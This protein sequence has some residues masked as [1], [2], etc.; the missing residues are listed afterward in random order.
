M[1]AGLISA[2][3]SRPGDSFR[4]TVFQAVVVNGAQVIPDNT[5]V[6]LQMVAADDGLTVQ[7][8]GITIDGL[9]IAAGPSQVALDPQTAASN[10]VIQ[11]AIAAMAA[12]PRGAPPQLAARL[13][14]VSGP[15]LNLPSGSRIVFTLLAPVAIDGTAPV[16]APRR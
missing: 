1:T 6:D 12:R 15:R 16:A 7:L 3:T 8:V 10:A 2:A 9:T 11:Q 14:A 4:G 5:A 13:V